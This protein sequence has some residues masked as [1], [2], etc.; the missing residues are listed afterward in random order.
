MIVDSWKTILRATK[1]PAELTEKEKALAKAID[2]EIA[3]K[4]RAYMRDHKD[5][6]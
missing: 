1:Q 5:A 6:G 3:A 2:A 4:I